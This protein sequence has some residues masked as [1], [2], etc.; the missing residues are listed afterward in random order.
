MKIL[1]LGVGKT[2]Q[3]FLIEGINQYIKQT[4]PYAKIEELYLKEESERADGIDLECDKILKA[5]PNGYYKIV[6]E[7]TGSQLSSEELAAAIENSMLKSYGGIVFIIGGHLG[8]NEKLKK[9]AD[10]LLS[11]SKATFTHQMI[12]LFLTEQIYRAFTILNNKTY[13][14]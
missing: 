5:I 7:R 11:F 10:L 13:H 2:K 14:R 12:R 6:L 3:A 1:L 4:S 8:I 9:Q